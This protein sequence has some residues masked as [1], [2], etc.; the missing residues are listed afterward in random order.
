[1]RA[2]QAR[3][4]YGPSVCLFCD[5]VN[6][7]FLEFLKAFGEF[8]LTSIPKHIF[9]SREAVYQEQGSSYLLHILIRTNYR[10]PQPCSI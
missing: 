10:V 5:M 1:M 3:Y 9:G 6:G 8:V 7:N 4:N 2:T